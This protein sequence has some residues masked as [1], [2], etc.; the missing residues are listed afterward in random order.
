MIDRSHGGNMRQYLRL[1][2]PKARK[3]IDFSANINPLG[4]PAGLEESLRRGI[5]SIT[6]YPEPDS[7]GLKKC[8]AAFHGVNEDNLSVGNGSI[9]LIYLIPKALK[10]KHILI[11]T[12]SFSEYEISAAINGAR[13]KFY[14]T[15]EDDGFRVDASRLRNF[16]PRSGLLFLGNPNNPTGCCLDAGEILSLAAQCRRHNSVL[17]LDQAFADF[18]GDPAAEALVGAPKKNR[19]LIVIRSLTKFF[20]LPGLRI[21]YASGHRD[22]I[23]SICRLQYPWNV[24]SLAQQAAETALLDTQYMIKSIKYA[25]SERQYLFHNL[26]GIKGLK[27]Y[28]STTNFILCRLVDCAVSSAAALNRILIKK[29]MVVRDCANFRG[30]DTSYFRL[31][32]RTRHDN[33]R[34]ISA[35]KEAL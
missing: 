24:N 16:I 33:S 4:L 10:A 11:I 18:M 32:V 30:L 7:R 3:I 12:P 1:L 35:L 17:V 31:A 14:G 15:K 13:V 23:R 19:A 8:L 29:N 21:G 2:E 9:E 26:C 20:A 34:L 22:V 27:T 25:S 5:A 6:H 28:P